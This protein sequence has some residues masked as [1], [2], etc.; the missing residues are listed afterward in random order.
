[1]KLIACGIFERELKKLMQDDPQL[2]VGVEPVFLTPAL[3]V[4]LTALEKEINGRLETESIE[5]LL[6]GC[7]CHPDLKEKCR[8][9]QCLLP[10]EVDCAEILA[11]KEFLTEI[12]QGGDEFYLTPG[13]LEYS[14]EIFKQGL[15]WDTIDAR[16]NL[17]FYN[18]V[19]LL[20]TGVRPIDDLEIL[21]FY[22][23]CQVPVEIVP[24]SLEHFKSRLEK[25]LNGKQQK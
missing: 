13:W 17:G 8:E 24:L 9:K 4:D 1:M 23:Y 6:Y 18:R 5:S 11:G 20:D 15:G 22:D 21:E 2:F 16:Q 14:D 3:H 7:N 12:N 19:V 25:L 10:T